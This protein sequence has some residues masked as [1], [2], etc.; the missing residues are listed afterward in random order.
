MKT[1]LGTG[2]AVNTFL[3][4]FDREGVG[5]GSFYR[6]S[7]GE[8][9]PDGGTWQSQGYDETDLPRP[10]NGRLM[11]AHQVMCNAAAAPATG[12][13][14]IACKGQQDF[15]VGTWWWLH[16]SIH[17]K[18]GQGMRIH[19]EKMLNK[20]GTNDFIPVYLEKGRSQFLQEPR[21]EV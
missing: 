21:S 15:Y 11:D 16:V 17:N 2:A 4:N 12:A 8:W 5:D 1:N 6:T 20:C 14:E 19:F 10:L 3:V 9:I 13:A 7:S 18:F